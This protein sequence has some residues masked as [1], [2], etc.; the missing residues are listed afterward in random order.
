[1]IFLRS[2]AI[3]VAT[4]GLCACA[5]VQDPRVAVLEKRLQQ[6]Q[7]EKAIREVVIRYGE[8]L[9]A[10]DYAAYALPPR[11]RIGPPWRLRVAMLMSLSA[12]VGRGRSRSAPLMG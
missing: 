12:R 7:D 8:Y 1:M 11:P 4:L 6:L 3:L 10:R 9:D 5:T 2:S